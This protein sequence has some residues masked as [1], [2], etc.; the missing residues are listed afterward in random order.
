MGS[1]MPAHAGPAGAIL[2]WLARILP[3]EFVRRVAEPALSD[4][5]YRWSETGRVPPFARTRFVCS[6]LWVGI[7][8][9]FWN[10][11]RPTGVTVVLLGSALVLIVALL[12]WA[13]TIYQDLPG[14]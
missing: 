14:P 9:V 8:R 10:R 12:L 7:P 1:S 13:G 3:K 11:R 6:C 2:V 5:V 4:E